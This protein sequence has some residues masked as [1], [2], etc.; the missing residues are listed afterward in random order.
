MAARINDVHL[1]L[2]SI[3][4]GKSTLSEINALIR[5]AF[6]FSFARLKQLANNGQININSFQISLEAASIDCI[7][8]M[9]KRNQN[10]EFVEIMDFF[11]EE[12]SIELLTMEAAYQHFRSLVFTKLQDG[13]A[14]LYW[15]SDPIYS[16][17]IRNLKIH[18]RHS[19]TINKFEM[20]G[21]IYIYSCNENEMNDNFPEFPLDEFESV[22]ISQ[23]REKD[24][25]K[26]YL[27]IAL[28][29]LMIRKNIK[30][31]SH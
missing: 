25:I 28:N 19:G 23:I 17:I 4:S 10:G 15:D 29:I 12:R 31:S 8:D 22:L 7:A 20:F 24:N 16:K 27:D 9:F 5:I 14:R 21:E 13:I 30:N 1:L 6:Q 26:N 3:L 2:K 11:S 18:L